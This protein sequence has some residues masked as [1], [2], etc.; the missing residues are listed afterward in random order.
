MAVVEGSEL[1]DCYRIHVLELPDTMVDIDGSS[2][3][4]ALVVLRRR[5]GAL[6]AVPTG[7][8]APEVF[9]QGLVAE[10][11]DQV[12]LSTQILVAAG[13]VTDFNS[14]EQPQPEEG[15]TVGVLL[16]DV[17]AEIG[18]S[19]KPYDPAAFPLDILHVFHVDK[20]YL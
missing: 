4:L 7:V 2:I 19:L 11:E 16:V 20:P 9:S 18:D 17:S 15:E 13:S 12:G 3:A 14:G 10:E 6:L 5:E 1:L 8:F